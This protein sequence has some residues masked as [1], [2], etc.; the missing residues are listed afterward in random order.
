MPK[1]ARPVLA[2][3]VTTPRFLTAS[4]VAPASAGA[5]AATSSPA[6]RQAASQFSEAIAI[7]HGGGMS[8]EARYHG[9]Q[10]PR[11][12][13][14]LPSHGTAMQDAGKAEQRGDHKRCAA[15]RRSPTRSSPMPAAR[16]Q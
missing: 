7:L 11:N 14:A 2:A 9:L 6:L 10:R 13:A 5:V 4:R 1:P 15:N 16:P 12:A 3:Q 8:G